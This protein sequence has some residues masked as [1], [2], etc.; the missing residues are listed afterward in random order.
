MKDVKYILRLT[1]TLLLITAF[2]AA[3]LAGV[4]AITKEKIAA[5]QQEK[6]DAAKKEVL[7]G[8]D[9]FETVDFT[10]DEKVKAVYVPV[11][12]EGYV[13]QVG[14]GGFGGDITMMVGVKDGAV[15]GVAIV[16]QQETAGLGAVAADQNKGVAFRN[17]FVGMAEE[18]DQVDAIS[19]ATITSKAVLSG[20]NAALS[21]KM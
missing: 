13:A 18:S 21:V 14:V 5:A 8:Y 3:A 15:C 16:S 12:G 19:G 17:Q 20:V 9:S 2:V 11:G 10:A 4:N 7:P 1:V 6:A